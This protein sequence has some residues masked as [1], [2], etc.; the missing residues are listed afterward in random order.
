M[1]LGATVGAGSSG[2]IINCDKLF[3]MIGARRGEC[4]VSS[5]SGKLNFGVG[6]WGG[7][8]E[9]SGYGRL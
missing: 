3:V 4:Q 7:G 2:G 8:D 9:P 6:T 1:Y 5:T